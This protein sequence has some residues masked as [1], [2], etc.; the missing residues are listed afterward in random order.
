MR[1]RLLLFALAIAVALLVPSPAHAIRF[2]ILKEKFT[3]N[4]TETLFVAYHG[5]IGTGL[6]V[7]TD[8]MGRPTEQRRFADLL[9][10]LIHI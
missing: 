6:V 2:S 5:D 10:S 9:L 8:T 1:S 3:L 7:E 4:I